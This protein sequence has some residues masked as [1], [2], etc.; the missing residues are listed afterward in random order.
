MGFLR[1]V[2]LGALACA[3]VG[4]EVSWGCGR[5]DGPRDMHLTTLW[6]GAGQLQGGG[7]LQDRPLYETGKNFSPC[8]TQRLQFP[9]IRPEPFSPLD[10][11]SRAQITSGG[12][13]TLWGLGFPVL[14]PH[15]P[16]C[17]SIAPALGS[18]ASPP[19][20][21]SPLL[22]LIGPRVGNFPFIFHFHALEEETAT[23]LS[24]L[25]W[26][27]PRREEPGGLQSMESQKSWTPLIN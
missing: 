26:R 17:D 23:H 21:F 18:L 19:G 8:H 25:A 4:R 3:W 9:Q 16:E 27:I 5:C 14:A 22:L 2:L 12:K 10:P 6:E 1:V 13:T 7:S 20:L 24:I 11:P 15:L